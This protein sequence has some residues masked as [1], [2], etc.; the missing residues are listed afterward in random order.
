[1]R[2][3]QNIN[4]DRSLEEGVSGWLLWMISSGSGV[5]WRK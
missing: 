1:M 3:G 5:Q 2:S 4:I